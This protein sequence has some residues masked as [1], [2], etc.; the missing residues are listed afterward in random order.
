MANKGVWIAWE[1][2]TRSRSMS[3]ALRLPLC[4]IVISGGRVKRYLKSIYRTFAIVRDAEIDVV[5]FQNPSIVLS[6]FLTSIRRLHGKRLIMDAHNAGIRPLEGKSRFLVAVARWI[7]RRVDLTIVTNESL[8][9]EVRVIGGRPVVLTDPIPVGMLQEREPNELALVAEYVLVVC[10]WADDEPYHELLKAAALLQTDG[11]KVHFTGKPPLQI[12]T[13]TQS[14]NVVLEGFVSHQ[15]YVRLLNRARLIIDLTTRD[16][17][18]VCGAY[19]AAAVGRPCVLSNTIISRKVFK[20]GFIF[21]G[22][23]ADEIA[24]TV[25]LGLKNSAV[26]SQEISAFREQYI[27]EIDKKLNKLSVELDLIPSAQ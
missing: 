1:N 21:T 26:L 9:E 14:D 18:L 16:N 5:F 7:V 20:S 8:A 23:Q 22:N 11:I 24:E 12:L 2:H 19:E 4:E 15:E 17:C 6:L 13:S 10:T 25:R 27:A 3:R